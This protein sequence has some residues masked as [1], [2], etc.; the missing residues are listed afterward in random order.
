MKIMFV[1]E[2]KRV[3][4]KKRKL[5]LSLGIIVDSEKMFEIDQS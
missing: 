1:D 5:F 4:L 3:E 2:S